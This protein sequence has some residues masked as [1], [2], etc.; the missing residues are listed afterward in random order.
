[1]LLGLDETKMYRQKV[2]EEERQVLDEHLFIIGE[3]GVC[4]WKVLRET[5]AARSD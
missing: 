4:L 1:M 2:G 3:I 5:G